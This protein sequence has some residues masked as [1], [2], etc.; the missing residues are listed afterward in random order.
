MRLEQQINETP[1]ASEIRQQV[2]FVVGDLEELSASAL[3]GNLDRGYDFKASG[4]QLHI[5]EDSELGITGAHLKRYGENKPFKY[6]DNY[7]A[8][9]GEVNAAD[10]GIPKIKI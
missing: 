3:Y 1:R 10:I 4:F 9:M 2:Y 5:H 7:E 8:L 6:L